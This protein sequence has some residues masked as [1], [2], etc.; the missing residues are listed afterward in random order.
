MWVTLTAKGTKGRNIQRKALNV[1]QEAW[2]TIP[3]DNLQKS[4]ESSLRG[5]R[6]CQ[7]GTVVISK[8]DFQTVYL[9][10]SIG[11]YQNVKGFHITLTKRQTSSL[12]GDSS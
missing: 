7:R 2:Q 6:L 9:I 10:D 8:T 4:Q 12:T 1:P 3:E 11:M 5:F